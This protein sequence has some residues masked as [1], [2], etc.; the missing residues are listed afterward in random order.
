MGMSKDIQ[1]EEINLLK[2][3]HRDEIAKLVKNK[4]ILEQQVELLTMQLHEASDR[5][6]EFKNRY[7]TMI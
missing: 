6:R 4:A 7:T 5:E 2:K 3:M 1:S